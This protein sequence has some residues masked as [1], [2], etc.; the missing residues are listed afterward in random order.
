MENNNNY[1]R[2]ESQQ[3]DNNLSLQDIWALCVNH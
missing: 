2:P 3:E 1:N